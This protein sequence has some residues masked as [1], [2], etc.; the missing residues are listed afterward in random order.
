[1]TD[2]NPDDR[3][4]VGV[5]GVGSMGRH[6]ARVYSELPEVELVG[7]A[8][9]DADRASDIAAKHA[10]TAMSREDVLDA[11]DAVSVAVPTA[12]HYEVA[13]QAIERGVHVLVEKPFVEQL[14]EGQRLRSLADDHAVTVQVGHV[15]RFNPAV[16]ALAD[17]VEEL[18]IIAVDAQRL[19]P[20]PERD[21]ED[22]AILDLMI[23]DVD[24]VLS[25][26]DDDLSFVDAVGT[27]D[28]HHAVA[29]LQFENGVVGSLA[30]SRVTQQK[31]RTLSITAKECRV[32]VD[33]TDRSIE[34]HRRSLPEYV[35]HDGDLHY[36]YESVVERPTVA[37]TEPL[38][39]QL[40]AF[41]AAALDGTEPAVT[42]A[43]GL[44]ALKV[45]REIDERAATRTRGFAGVN[46]R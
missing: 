12:Y 23:H 37:N 9:V 7:V 34:I 33:Y 4:R 31:V 19:G 16:M 40:S 29:T 44:R 43:D 5:I 39:N 6:H 28:N 41:A 10:T 32:N 2:V 36:R 18:D 25:L 15:E 26:V 46:A 27:Q 35:E 20:P 45:V 24:V 11:A 13:Q 38:K 3:I 1:M 22:N 8:D 17:I 21:I 14:S 30:A 42:A